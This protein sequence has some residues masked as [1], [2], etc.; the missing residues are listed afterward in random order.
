MVDDRRILG[1]QL[2]SNNHLMLRLYFQ[3]RNTLQFQK[4]SKVIFYSIWVTEQNENS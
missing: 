1:T 3:Q 4:N 2:P